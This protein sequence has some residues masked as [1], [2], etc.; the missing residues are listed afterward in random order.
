[1]SNSTIQRRLREAGLF[2]P[3]PRKNPYQ[4]QTR[5]VKFC[6]DLLIL[7]FENL[8]LTTGPAIL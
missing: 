3:K 5:L 8:D 6:K 7:D 1:M 4:S 2:G